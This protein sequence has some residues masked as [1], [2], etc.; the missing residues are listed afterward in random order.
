MVLGFGGWVRKLA[1]FYV[2]ESLRVS[3]VLGF[4]VVTIVTSTTWVHDDRRR[5]SSS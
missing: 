4:E 1:R 2:N 3:G 5:C